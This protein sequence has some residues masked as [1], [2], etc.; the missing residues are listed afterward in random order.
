MVRRAVAGALAVLLPTTV[1]PARGQVV[2]PDARLKASDLTRRFAVPVAPAFLLVTPEAGS[3][4]RPQTARDVG[5]A[6]SHFQTSSGG[7]ALP[8]AFAVE[9]SPAILLNA[10]RRPIDL[11]KYS[12]RVS[13]ASLRD[14]APGAPTKL[15]VGFRMSITDGIAAS[16]DQV[17]QRS[18]RE[19]N[20]IVSAIDDESESVENVR[21][22]E[23]LPRAPRSAEDSARAREQDAAIAAGQQSIRRRWEDLTWNADVIDVAL[24]IGATTPDSTG[25]NPDLDQ[26]ALWGSWAKG[27]GR[28]GQA[29]LGLRLAWRDSVGGEG[30]QSGALGFRLYVGRNAHKA[31]VELEDQWLERAAATLRVAGGVELGL[32]EWIWFT[33]SLALEN[34]GTAPTRSVVAFRLN[35]GLPSF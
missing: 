25:A 1:L 15:A 5:V 13:A 24:A 35:T 33:A 21:P 34:P 22:G 27:W 2:S 18:L 6:L 29:L 16:G 20:T 32:A 28:W 19:I 17:I 14:T 7:L 11:R 26:V 12:F 8:R 9:F 3:I 4:L 31:F 30:R 10:D 23:A